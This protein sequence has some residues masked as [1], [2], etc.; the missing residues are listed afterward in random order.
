MKPALT[1]GVILALLSVSALNAQISN[2]DF[3]SGEGSNIGN[4]QLKGSY[5]YNAASQV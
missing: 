1:I 3:T 5:S 2:D 4:P